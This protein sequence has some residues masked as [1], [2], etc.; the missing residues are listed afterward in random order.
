MLLRILYLIMYANAPKSM[1]NMIIM[2]NSITTSFKLTEFTIVY[3]AALLC[4]SFCLSFLSFS[5][6]FVCSL[7]S[8]CCFNFRLLY[9]TLFREFKIEAFS[10][11]VL[12]N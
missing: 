4:F 3:S 11:S 8:F 10:N 7:L 2:Y 6:K 9:D 12:A 5:L 1:K